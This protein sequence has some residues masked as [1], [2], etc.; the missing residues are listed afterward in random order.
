MALA[1]D[2]YRFVRQAAVR[3]DAELRRCVDAVVEELSEHVR[4]AQ[5]S[6]TAGGLNLKQRDGLV[7]RD[8]LVDPASRC[9]G[10]RG[11]DVAVVVPD[12][13][14]PEKSGVDREDRDQR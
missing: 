12:P 13:V 10:L 11:E 2:V 14:R 3:R 9:A 6:L 7:V 4:V 1:A 5:L 8:D